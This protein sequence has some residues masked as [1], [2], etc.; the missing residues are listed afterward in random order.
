[1]PRQGASS[2]SAG[3]RPGNCPIRMSHAT[4]QH[5]GHLGQGIH[6]MHHRTTYLCHL[7]GTPPRQYL[8]CSLPAPGAGTSTQ[9]EHKR[10]SFHGRV[11]S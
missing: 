10:C 4:K 9:Q 7:S 3:D 5:T 8:S 2:H 6:R 11:T 1:M